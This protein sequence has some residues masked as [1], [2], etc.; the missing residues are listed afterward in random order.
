VILIADLHLGKEN[1]SYLSQGIPV[2]RLDLWNKLHYIGT[3]AHQTGQVLVIAGDVFNKLNPTTQII[4][5]WFKF[6]S[7]FP[8]VPIYVIP[9]NHDSGTD[10]VNTGMI[11]EV[12][13]SHVVAITEPGTFNI[14]DSTGT[15]K[16]LFYPHI[17]LA[18]RDKARS[19]AQMWR[20]SVDFCVTHGQVV[21]SEYSNDI[22]FEAGDALELDL[23][24]MPGLIFAGHIHKQITWKNT[25]ARV[26]YPGSMTINNFGEVDERKGYL[27]IR[28]EDPDDYTECEFPDHMGTRWQHVELDLTA[29]DETMLDEAAIAEIADSAIIKITVLAKQY[30]VVDE[31][32]VRALFNKYGGHVTRYETKVT[33]DR[34]VV[35]AQKKTVSH[36][37]LLTD[38]LGDSPDVPLKDRTNAK[39][40]GES[41]ITEVLA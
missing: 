17:P 40:M 32:Y 27:S 16:V 37:K 6:L 15:A 41:I 1:D 2:Q 13:M 4:A 7:A 10:W 39:K 34:T 8:E 38:W 11:K 24:K 23:A 3:L 35:T 19:I 25:K 22:F 28:L 36:V 9:G 33:G 5:L 12:K 26:V 30:G 14:V 29:K 20:G 31:S 21:N 18:Q